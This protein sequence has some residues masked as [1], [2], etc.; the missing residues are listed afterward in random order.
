M[1]GVAFEH[2]GRPVIR[3]VA[4]MT[5]PGLGASSSPRASR[6]ARARAGCRVAISP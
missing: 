2:H 1:L 5:T 6:G 3:V 4:R